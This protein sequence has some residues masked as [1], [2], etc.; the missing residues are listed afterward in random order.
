MAN[1]SI[2]QLAG[3]IAEALSEY[4]QEVNC[5]VNVL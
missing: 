4:S 2:D 1:I 5:Y 3:E